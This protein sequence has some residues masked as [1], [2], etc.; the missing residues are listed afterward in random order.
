[1]AEEMYKKAS[2]ESQA[3]DG[4]NP[5]QPSAEDVVDADFEEVD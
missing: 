4:A 1:L 3:A 5:E 2:E